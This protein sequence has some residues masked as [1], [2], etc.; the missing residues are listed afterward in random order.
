MRKLSVSQSMLL[1]DG[2]EKNLP[3]KSFT[4]LCLMVADVWE[5]LGEATKHL[6]LI[7]I[8]PTFITETTAQIHVTIVV[9]D[10][11]QIT[12]P[13]L[14]NHKKVE[15]KIEEKFMF[16]LTDEGSFIS[17]EHKI[18]RAFQLMIAEHA[19]TMDHASI[20]LRDE[21]A[22]LGLRE[23]LSGNNKRCD[24]CGTI[25]EERDGKLVC[26]KCYPPHFQT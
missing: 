1:Y 17:L 3:L 6:E 7:R 24:E 10:A 16:N 13:R 15:Q 4:G 26:D 8:I 14:E 12:N 19:K 2:R 5:R 11:N 9:S 21:L 18:V 23:E 25:R 20:N 22:N